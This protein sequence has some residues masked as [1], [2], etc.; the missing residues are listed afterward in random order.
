MPLNPIDVPSHISHE[1]RPPLELVKRVVPL[2]ELYDWHA[3]ENPHYPLFTYHDG[4]KLQYITYSTAN[5][6]IYF[7]ARYVMRCVSQSLN[8]SGGSATTSRTLPVVAIFANA[9]TI[10]YFC[11][12]LG[13]VRSGCTLFQIS[14][15]NSVA[16]V[17]DMLGRTGTTQLL[18]SEDVALQ[19][20]ALSA[21]EHFPAGQITIR[22]MPSFEDIFELDDKRAGS[23]FDV[24]DVALPE[25]LNL[26]APAIIL[27]SSGSSGHP[28]PMPWSHRALML[29]GHG[30]LLC[31]MD[32]RG[33]ILGCHGTPM[34]H[35]LGALMYSAS[36]ISG[37]IVA[38]FKPLTPPVAPSP[39]AVWQGIVATMSDFTWSVPSF[40]EAWASDPERVE[41]LR[42]M[43]G[44]LF[45]GAPLNEEIG[46]ALA[47]QGVSLFTVYG[48]SE[49]GLI[50]LF[51]RSDPGMD[52]P[53]FAPL[54]TMSLKFLPY[55]GTRFELVVLSNPEDPLPCINTRV[56]GHDGYATNDLLEAHPTKPNL[57][58][59]VGR[60]DEQIVL[61]NGEKTNPV[62]LEKIINKDPLIN[63]SLI[64]GRGKFHN[65]VLVEP[66]ATSA[67]LLKDA[68]QVQVFKNRIW[69]TIERANEYAPQH[70]RI[71]KEVILVASPSKPFQ[72]NM[73]GLLRRGVM[74]KAYQVEIDALYKEVENSTQAA[75]VLS[76]STWDEES[77]LSFVRAV[78][79]RTIHRSIADDDD[80]FRNGG[81][82]LQATWICNTI[83][84]ALRETSS[85]SAPYLPTDIVFKAPTISALAELI[86]VIVD[87]NDPI[88]FDLTYNP[89]M[90]L[91]YVKKYTSGL[92]PRLY[93]LMCRPS[94]EKDV[95]LITGTTGG[96][97]CDILEHLLRDEQVQRVYA[98][99]RKGTRALERQYTQFRA[100]GLDEQLLG[101]SKFN[102][103]E[104]ALEDR[105]LGISPQVYDEIQHSVTHIIHNAWRVH[106]KLS[107][108][109]FE[110]DLQGVRNLV[111]LALGSKY[112]EAPRIIFVSSIGVFSKY[113]G[114]IPAPEIPL[115]D[116]SVPSATGYS[117]SKWIAERIL[118][119]VSQVTGLH[120]TVVRLGQVCGD[121]TGYWNEKEWFPT[122][123]KS[124]HFLHC[125]PDVEGHVSWVP[126]YQGAKVL[127]EMRCSTEP[128][129]HLVHPRPVSWH[130]IIS[131][132]ADELGIP[133]VP[134]AEWLSALEKCVGDSGDHAQL[135][136]MRI[137]QALRLVSFY[138]EVGPSPYR[139][140]F[141]L[142]HLDTVKSTRMS[143]TLAS[144]GQL[145]E[146]SV[147]RWVTTWKNR[148]YL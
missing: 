10:T 19:D 34:F 36:P 30:T 133:L 108:Q 54:P 68:E 8:L 119:A 122:L 132:L 65:G 38:A 120:A 52:W 29:F 105:D 4:E 83:R 12:A 49:T 77:T 18:V 98:L 89:Q 16:A 23:T 13:V 97:G 109:S 32:T 74:L 114:P 28:K 47:A 138:R 87:A 21:L 59:I 140:A 75:E 26:N 100:R 129:L 57:W 111:D 66:A 115:D 112:T 6:A 110:T 126:S 104:A 17:A 33:S 93:P 92:P 61:S 11:T 60:A 2:T 31:D 39:D 124:A 88:D 44:V 130:M 134:Y 43:R 14:T 40:I 56:D 113:E 146:E 85:R 50:N 128:V 94:L 76:P 118:Q 9:D 91:E 27:H 58:R 69:P 22:R 107:L 90:L 131:K 41:V 102:M 24:G 123:V 148:G 42:S 35:G 15:R 141:G 137:H 106:F 95:V 20:I 103:V 48:I 101:S 80:I 121:R 125:L 143:E 117:Q 84:R 37:Y 63:C 67:N 147:Q 145:D 82:S 116:P 46:N 71:F 86:S 25:N 144:L 55:D 96:F 7:V 3:R 99:N 64:F 72:F 45:G 5:R 70:S 136:L 62:P 1:F 51:V 127:V 81:D 79:Q 135:E 53:Y 139:E 73:K 142:V 78:V